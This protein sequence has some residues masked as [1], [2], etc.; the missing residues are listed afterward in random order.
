MPVETYITRVAWPFVRAH[1]LLLSPV[2]LLSSFFVVPFLG[3]YLLLGAA[4]TVAFHAS[5]LVRSIATLHAFASL[6]VQI[7]YGAQL[8]I[9]VGKLLENASKAMS[10]GSY[11][12]TFTKNLLSTHKKVIKTD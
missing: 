6:I 8:Q 7:F 3:V 5:F 1:Y 10:M 12:W 2:I 4:W 9:I 11:G